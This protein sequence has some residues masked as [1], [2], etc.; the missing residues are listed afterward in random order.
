[1]RVQIGDSRLLYA[2][3]ERIRCM[4]DLNADWSAIANSLGTD[5]EL[6]ARLRAEPGLRVPGCW[7]PFELTI[8]AILGQQITVK[9]ATSLAGRMA[10]TFGQP[11]SGPEGLT[12]LFP[13][14]AALAEAKLTTIGLTTKRAETIRAL[15]RAVCDGEISFE[16][17]T[18]CDAFLASLCSIPGIGAWTAQY[19]AMRAL[20]EPDAFPSSDLGLL[21]ALGLTNPRELEAR[22]NGWRPWRAYA[23]MYLWSFPFGETSARRRVSQAPEKYAAEA[24]RSN[25]AAAR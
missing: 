10:K 18:D 7:N 5:P 19:V 2:I 21:R 20:G 8:R 25:V 17:I 14:P 13:E 12:H 4:F 11:F 9:G 3:I 1:V 16:R 22:A 15:A 6:A 24:A 23:G